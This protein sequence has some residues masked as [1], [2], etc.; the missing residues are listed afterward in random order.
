MGPKLPPIDQ[1]F[2]FSYARKDETNTAEDHAELIYEF[3]Q[4]LCDM[5]RS[6]VNQGEQ[7][8]LNE[9]DPVGFIDRNLPVGSNYL[10]SLPGALQRCKSIVCLYSSR[11]FTRMICGQEVQV[12]IDRV[13]NDNRRP[14]VILPIFWEPPQDLTIPPAMQPYQFLNQA[15]PSEYRELGLRELMKKYMAFPYRQ[16]LVVMA[17]WVIRAHQLD[18]APL[19]Q[20]VNINTHPMAFPE[21]P[22]AVV[23]G[24]PPEGPRA[25]RFVYVANSAWAWAPFPP[26]QPPPPPADPIGKL[27]ALIALQKGFFPDKLDLAPPFVANTF[28]A[29][30]DRSKANNTPVVLLVDPRILQT[31]AYYALLDAYDG[32]NYLNCAAMVVW[33]SNTPL[34]TAQALKTLISNVFDDN[35]ARTSQFFVEDVYTADDLAKKLPK[36]L[37]DLQTNV[38]SKGAPKREVPG[39]GSAVPTI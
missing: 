34:L 6:L 16:L 31:S 15:L 9:Q 33:D 14:E 19:P 17:N 36:V 18:L 4:N 27:A 28:L 37:D 22:A 21:I 1:Y 39:T 3:F 29:E 11:Y 30:L 8:L 26:P 35:I 2:F 38:R 32:S 23:S 7:G 20:A 12:F 25:V 5:I 24:P 10:S 13:N